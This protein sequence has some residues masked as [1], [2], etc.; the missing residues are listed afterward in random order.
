[1]VTTKPLTAADLE[2]LGP[3]YRWFELIDGVLHERGTMGGRHGEIGFDLGLHVGIFVADHR[4]GRLYTS[5]T[6]FILSRDPY[7]VRMP[8]VAFVRADRLPPEQER[9]GP[10]PLAPDLVV[11]VVSPDDRYEEVT[12]KIELYQRAG[13]PLLWLVEPRRKTVTIYAAGHEPRSLTATDTLDGGNVLPGFS[14]P[15][16]DVFR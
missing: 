3:D 10:M 16:A 5:D 2:E 8:D 11:E 4:L 14:L 1:M 6:R 12:Q 15:V 7:T 13:V 9:V